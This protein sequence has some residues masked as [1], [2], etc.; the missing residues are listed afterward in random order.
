VHPKHEREVTRGYAVI[1][2]RVRGKRL[3]GTYDSYADALVDH[4]TAHGLSLVDD[5]CLEFAEAHLRS[6]G[7]R[8]VRATIT[9]EWRELPSGLRRGVKPVL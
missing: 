5:E 3:R 8:V 9:V 4:A 1:G 7:Q 6:T 2:R